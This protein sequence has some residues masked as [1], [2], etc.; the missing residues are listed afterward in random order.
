MADYNFDQ[1]IDRR[2]S[3]SLKWDVKEGELPMWVADMDFQTAPEIRRALA[4]R[5]EHGIFGYSTVPDEWYLAYQSLWETRHHFSIEKQWLIF[6]T[7]VV[8]AI[9]S[10]MRKLTTPGENVLIQT[11]VYNIFFHS[12]LNNGRNVLESPLKYRDGVYAPQ[13]CLPQKDAGGWTEAV[14]SR[15]TH[16]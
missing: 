6:V 8:P 1:I 5:V 4:R 7:G 3:S 13:Y 16:L 14:G 15:R 2:N 12:I 10:A 9:S 11:P